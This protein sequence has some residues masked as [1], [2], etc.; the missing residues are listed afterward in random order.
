MLVIPSTRTMYMTWPYKHMPQDFNQRG[1]KVSHL[2]CVIKPEVTFRRSYC[3][4]T[5]RPPVSRSTQLALDRLRGLS[6]VQS[7]QSLTRS[8]LISCDI[9]KSICQ[10]AYILEV[11]LKFPPE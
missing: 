1:L 10:S 2:T 9:L 11:K 7:K 3:S 4:L 8:F 6:V 5:L